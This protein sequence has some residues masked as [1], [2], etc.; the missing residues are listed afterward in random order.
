[1][2]RMVSVMVVFGVASAL[3]WSQVAFGQAGVPGASALGEEMELSSSMDIEGSI[4]GFMESED[5][6]M[7][8]RLDDGTPLTVAATTEVD[9]DY[10]DRVGEG[11]VTQLRVTVETQAP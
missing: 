3:S 6:T 1:M 11:V 9:A 5:G 7:I 4:A 10:Q 8:A 2:Y